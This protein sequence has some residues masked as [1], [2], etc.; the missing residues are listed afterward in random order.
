MFATGPDSVGQV[1]IGL[2]LVSGLIAGTFF[3]LFIVPTAYAPQK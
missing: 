1:N 2:V 3:S